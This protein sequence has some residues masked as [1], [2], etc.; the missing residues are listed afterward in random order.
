MLDARRLNGWNI[1]EERPFTY[2]FSLRKRK[3]SAGA[4][5]GEYGG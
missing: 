1:F 2:N 4:K 3:K 5:S